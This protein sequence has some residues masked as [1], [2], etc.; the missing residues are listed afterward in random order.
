MTR[1]FSYDIA[2]VVDK[3]VNISRKYN[4]TPLQL[5]LLRAVAKIENPELLDRVLK[6]T[7]AVHGPGAA[8]VGLVSALAENGQENA[9]RKTLI[10]EF[11]RNFIKFFIKPSHFRILL[12]L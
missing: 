5:E 10:V 4:C 6:E 8:Q 2:A 12:F 7:E 3:F 11:N 1:D 9:L